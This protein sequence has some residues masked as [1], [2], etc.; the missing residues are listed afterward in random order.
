MKLKLLINF[1]LIL[2]IMLTGELHILVTARRIESLEGDGAGSDRFL[3]LGGNSS[4][5][6]AEMQSAII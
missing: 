2:A 5:V 6:G 3:F 1:S 4:S